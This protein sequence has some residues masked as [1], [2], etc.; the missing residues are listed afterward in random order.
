[1]TSLIASASHSSSFVRIMGTVSKSR[2]R[3]AFSSRSMRAFSVLAPSTSTGAPIGV[4]A[5]A[6]AARA[7]PP[8][9]TNPT[10]IA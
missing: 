7:D 3:G 1:M 10:P 4:A 6:R 2:R 8:I 9:A 5:S